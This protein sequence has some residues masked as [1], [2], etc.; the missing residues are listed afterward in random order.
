[1]TRY[2]ATIKDRRDGSVISIVPFHALNEKYALYIAEWLA[3]G[4]Y[5]PYASVPTPDDIRVLAPKKSKL[6]RLISVKSIC[7]LKIG[8]VRDTLFRCILG[9]EGDQIKLDFGSID[10]SSNDETKLTILAEVMQELPEYTFHLVYDNP[11][12]PFGTKHSFDRI[13]ALTERRTARI[14]LGDEYCQAIL[15]SGTKKKALEDLILNPRGGITRVRRFRSLAEKKAY[16]QGLQDAYGYGRFLELGGTDTNITKTALM[17][18]VE[19]I[20]E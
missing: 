17:I 15:N 6:R 19:E 3:S 13:M 8:R 2:I 12:A 20:H 5:A 14:A 1:M 16:M 18:P 11:D 4:K 9:A 7:D 10:V